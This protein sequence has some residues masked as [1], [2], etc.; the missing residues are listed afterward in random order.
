M[1]KND[2]EPSH[3]H[4]PEADYSQY[5]NMSTVDLFKLFFDDDIF[6][7][8]NEQRQRY[9]QYKNEA[10]PGISTSET[11]CFIAIL[12]SSGYNHLPSK[13]L[14]WDMTEGVHNNMVARS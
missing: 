4:F 12:I 9:S 11:R 2:L 10:D 3:K 7:H 5:K 1:D 13:K 14:Y 8:L 6:H